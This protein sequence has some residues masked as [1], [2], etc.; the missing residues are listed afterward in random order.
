VLVIVVPT[1]APMMMGTADCRFNDPAA[2][3]ATTS[4]VV[5]ELL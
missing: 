3:I 5:V 2:T 4:A 1:F